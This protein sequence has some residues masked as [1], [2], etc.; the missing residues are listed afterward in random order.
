MS[1]VTELDLEIE[2]WEYTLVYETQ[3]DDTQPAWYTDYHGVRLRAHSKVALF[4]RLAEAIA[5]HEGE[6]D[7]LAQSETEGGG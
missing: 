1:D 4:H 2:E 6:H 5:V 3:A 7:A